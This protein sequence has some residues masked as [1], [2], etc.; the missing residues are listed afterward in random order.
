MTE[1]TSSNVFVLQ[2]RKLRS[3]KVSK[4]LMVIVSTDHKLTHGS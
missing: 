1:L 3:G 4:L 2:M